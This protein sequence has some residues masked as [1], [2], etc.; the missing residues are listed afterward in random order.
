MRDWDKLPKQ[1]K[2][3]LIAWFNSVFEDTKILA[4]LYLDGKFQ[5]WD[6]P[7]CG[8]RV[9]LAQP[10]NWKDFQGVLQADFI[11]YPG[12]KEK[13]QESWICQQCDDC[14]ELFFRLQPE[15][16]TPPTEFFLPCKY[17]HATPNQKNNHAQITP[18][19]HNI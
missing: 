8:D 11:S 16:I 1:V 17:H 2:I 14:R 10:D 6:C 7:D 12:D 13:Y 4:R 18:N 9:Y 3:D 15:E 5:A 19:I